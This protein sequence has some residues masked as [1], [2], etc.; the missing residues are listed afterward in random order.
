MGLTNENPT[1]GPKLKLVVDV[2]EP[3]C[4][5]ESPFVSVMLPAM[6]PLTLIEMFVKKAP[7]IL[8]CP[9]LMVAETS[10]VGPEAVEQFRII[11]DAEAAPLHRNRGKKAKQYFPNR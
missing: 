6:P 8:N 7:P 9:Q 10:S 5:L 11:V 2:P 1:K 4:G 3:L